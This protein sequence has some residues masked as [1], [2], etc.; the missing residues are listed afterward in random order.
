MLIRALIVKTKDLKTYSHGWATCIGGSMNNP[1]HSGRPLVKKFLSH[2]IEFRAKY[3]D[4]TTKKLL[5]SGTVTT[6]SGEKFRCRF[7]D[8]KSRKGLIQKLGL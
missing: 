4:D 7:I 3:G 8:R 2:W 5:S 6:G 1:D